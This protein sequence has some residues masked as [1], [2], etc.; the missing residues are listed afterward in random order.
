M[1]KDAKIIRALGHLRHR[2]GDHRFKI[3]DHW[4]G[5][6]HAVGIS[7]PT[8]PTRLVYIAYNLQPAETY[9]AILECRPPAGCDHPYEECGRFDNADL[10]S[11]VGI[12]SDHLR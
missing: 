2:L 10:E 8:D 6:L 5:D 3:T 9:T 4:E 12:V 7:H 1:Q 11:L